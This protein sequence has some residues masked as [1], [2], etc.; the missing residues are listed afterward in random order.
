MA[1]RG[2]DAGESLAA[3]T[4]DGDLSVNLGPNRLSL[5]VGALS[6]HLVDRTA[7]V[8]ERVGKKQKTKRTSF[9]ITGL[10]YGRGH[11][12]DDIGL[13]VEVKEE[14]TKPAGTKKPPV[15]P[16]RE[17][18]V[19][20]FGISPVSLMEPNGLRSL[21]K[22]ENVASRLRVHVED[23]ASAAGI[24]FARG[25]EIGSGHPLDKVL[26]ADYG[27]HHAIYARKLFRD[28]ARFLA[29]V[30][31]D[32]GKVSVPNGDKTIE[33]P[34]VSRFGVT[35]RGDYIRFADRHGTDLARISVPWVGPED[36]E[37]LARRIGQLVHR[38]A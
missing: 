22:L 35:V 20:I 5:A 15:K 33:V 21:A 12:R 32:A 2:E 10:V 11:P 18:L 1:Y 3:P 31:H 28:R 25:T 4:A 30:H 23:Y 13:W 36:R 7:T 37:E 17:S 14:L 34:V 19:R 27:D 16:P 26:F 24:W 29:S 38:A 6:L 9:S 8:T